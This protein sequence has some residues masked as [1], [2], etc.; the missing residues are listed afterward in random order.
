MKR[1]KKFPVTAL[2][3]GVDCAKRLVEARSGVALSTGDRLRE[4]ACDLNVV[5]IDGGAVRS[6]GFVKRLPDGK[7]AISFASDCSAARRRFTVAHELAHLILE[8]FH[9]HLDQGMNAGHGKGY[10]TELER[11][12]DRIAAELLM[13]HYLVAESL[14]AHCDLHL[15]QSGSR[16]VPKRL[17]VRTV[18]QTLGV[19][20]RAL[21]HRLFELPEL[22]TVLIRVEWS[23]GTKPTD[24]RYFP[25]SYTRHN[26]SGVVAGMYPEPQCLQRQDGWEHL[27]Q[28]ETRWGTR[29]LHCQA[30]RRP[31]KRGKERLETW[32]LGWTWNTFPPPPWDD[33]EATRSK[34]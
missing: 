20:E 14:R 16:I 24:I 5:R 13:P 32:I 21:V 9:K 31:A 18:G 34:R 26:C 17:V 12:V 6:A 7:F 3:R 29:L 19:S 15:R 27:V 28:V 4:I 10:C 23:N 11:A 33:S 22:V 1:R 2:A 25:I 30:W 8:K